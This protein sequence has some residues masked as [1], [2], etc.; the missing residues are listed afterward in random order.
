MKQILQINVINIAKHHTA[1]T[2]NV[3]SCIIKTRI[4][5]REKTAHSL[6]S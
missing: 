5:L 2:F 6:I 3:Q 1:I 4:S